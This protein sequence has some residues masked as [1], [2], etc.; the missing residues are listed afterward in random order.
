MTNN[1]GWK[2]DAA[3]VRYGAAAEALVRRE[4]GRLYVVET[5]E[6]IGVTAEGRPVLDD[7]LPLLDVLPPMTGR[8]WGDPAFKRTYGLRYAYVGGSMANGIS[9][10]AMVIAL[11]KA[12][13]LGSFG[14]GGMAPPRLEAAIREVQAA[15]PNGPYAFN[16]I[17]NPIE[18]AMEEATAALYLRYGVPV[19]EASAYM[20]LTPYLV[21]YRAAGLHRAPDGQIV[22]GHR[23]L[24][25]LSRREVAR[26]F[27][28]P[29]PE[30]L[31]RDL[32][33]AGKITAE[34]AA[35]A[36][37]VPM[38]D[39]ITVE[40]DSGGHTDN[41]PLVNLLPSMLTLRDEVQAERHY[42]SPVRIGAAGGI[43]TPQAVLGALMMGAAY[44]LTG[45]INQSCVEA[46]TSATVK[47]M[48]AE[49]SMTDVMMAPA[50]DMFEMGV[51]VQVLKRGTLFPMRARKLY[52]LY[53]TYES[54]EAIPPKER[55][56]LE[57]QIFRMS[58]EEVWQ[59]CIDFFSER[60]PSQIEK[61]ERNPKKKMALVFRWYLG[62]AT[63]WA[64]RG[65][66]QR[67]QDY[68]IWCGPAMGAFNDWVRGTPL[69]RPE[70]RRVAEI[71]KLLMDEAAALY[72]LRRYHLARRRDEA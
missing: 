35:M 42:P 9:S 61:A 36:S 71:G 40:A 34:Q 5:P 63:Y 11:G 13:M 12:G 68:Q 22:I 54:L 56:K 37:Q 38:A 8:D 55:E 3:S 72:R 6:G 32:V 53:R 65:D 64:I 70:E 14:A 43:S 7:G 48:L 18:P 45:S 25:K 49:A 57:R 58:I 23:V 41:R 1:L 21:H 62:L 47:Q 39:D 59:A 2:G 29:A 24:A 60:D 20:R 26:R 67:K 15:L 69:A 44:V 66:P 33:A 4:K 31:L 50:A 19:I 10:T 52:E 46:G 51:E 28:E 17:H 27:L 16:L 30:R